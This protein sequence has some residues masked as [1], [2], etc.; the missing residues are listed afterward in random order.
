MVGNG[1]TGGVGF[2]GGGSSL[3]ALKKK[4][5]DRYQSARDYRKGGGLDEKRK[6]T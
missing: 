2:G 1:G 6:M 5:N 4:E 3:A